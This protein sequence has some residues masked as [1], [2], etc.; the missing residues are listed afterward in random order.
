MKVELLPALTDNYMYLVIDEDTREAAIVDPVQPQK[1]LET[2]KKHGVKLTTVLTTH[3]H[4]DH[5]GGNE[6]LVK[7]EPGLKVYGGDDRIGALTHKVTHLTTLQVTPCSWLAVGSSTKGPQMRCT[8]LCSRSWAGFLQTQRSTVATS[9]PS[10]TSSS[11]ATWN[12]TM[13]PFKRNWPGPRRS[14][15]LGSLRCHPPWRR[16]SPTTPS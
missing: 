13:L 12:L 1:V 4:W 15:A 2:V 6:K 8:K 10:T 5:A 9:T 7:L 14:T 3:H 16:S 11:R